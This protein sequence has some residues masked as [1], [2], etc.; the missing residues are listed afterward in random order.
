MHIKDF[1]DTIDHKFRNA[2]VLDDDRVEADLIDYTNEIIGK[3][4]YEFRG[5]QQVKGIECY[6]GDK[7]YAW[8]EPISDN[9]FETK[10]FPDILSIIRGLLESKTLVEIIDD[11]EAEKIINSYKTS[12]PKTDASVVVPSKNQ[13]GN[14]YTV[15]INVTFS[16]IVKSTTMDHALSEFRDRLKLPDNVQYTITNESVEISYK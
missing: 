16:G 4:L 7:I 3:L 15:N 6:I 14:Q 2:R 8:G 12:E 5:Q 1:F 11:T 9:V 10:T 13:S